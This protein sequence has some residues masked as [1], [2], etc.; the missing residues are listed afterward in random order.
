MVDLGT[1][2]ILAQ[3]GTGFFVLLAGLVTLASASPRR[4]TISFSVFLVLWGGYLLAG[5]LAYLAVN[6]GNL[7]QGEELLILH[8]VMQGIA[9]LPLVVFTLSY[10]PSRRV[11]LDRWPALALLLAPAL[12]VLAV[13]LADPGLFHEGFALAD[14]GPEGSWG[15]ARPIV[16]LVFHLAMFAVLARLVLV[17]ERSTNHLERRQALY[18]L[19]GFSLFVGFESMENLVI[20]SREASVGDGVAALPSLVFAGVSLLG[21]GV[22]VWLAQRLLDGRNRLSGSPRTLTTVCLAGSLG[23]GLMAGGSSV[24]SAV[25]DFPAESVWRLGTV[26]LV[27]SAVTR[28]EHENPVHVLPTLSAVL[29]WF[30][31]GAATLLTIHVGLTGLLGSATYAFVGLQLLLGGGA[32]LIAWR[33]PGMIAEILRK[34]RQRRSPLGRARRDLELYEAALLADSAAQTL[35][36]LREEMSISEAEHHIVR[37]LADP[38]SQ[39]TPPSDQTPETGDVLDDRYELT[40]ILGEGASSTVF[41]AVDRVHAEEV[42]VKVLDPVAARDR[43][44]LRQFVYESRVCLRVQHPNLIEAHALGYDGDLPYLAIELVEAGTLEA[45][46][47]EGGLST[48]AACLIVD[49]V[50]AGIHHLHSEGLLHRDLKP[51]NILVDGEGRAKIGDLGLVENWDAQRTQQLGPEGGPTREGTPA[52]MSPEVLAGRPPTPA[53]DV[54][55]VGA[56]LVEALTGRHYLGIEDAPYAAVKRAVLE[57]PPRLSEVQP[58]LAA[59][60]RRALAKDP[61]RRYD[62]AAEM[63]KAIR[64]L[65]DVDPLAGAELVL[66]EIAPPK[67]E[68]PSWRQGG[69]GDPSSEREA[70]NESA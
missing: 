59:I 15:P 45:H 31:V 58:E 54:Y 20:F 11:D 46:L 36:Q 61:S 42:A 29:G 38:S 56:I 8:S 32:A 17:H 53:C 50:L 18:V 39:P 7:A 27:M 34:L 16:F 47:E 69:V 63:R 62:S 26:A 2:G 33:R 24:W 68:A 66:S 37:Q 28:F 14:A 1:V 48:R 4:H 3:A 60:C 35:G 12:A 49:D 21:I 55:A 65:V 44:E 10:P 30:A 51:S 70:V 67:R 23:L 6:A 57:T 52:Y 9:Y 22:L 40:G 43:R 13:V 25:P 5:N 64:D 41:Q 19:L